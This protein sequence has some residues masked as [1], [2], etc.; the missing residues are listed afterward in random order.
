MIVSLTPFQDVKDNLMRL[1]PDVT[2]DLLLK[3]RSVKG[4]RDQQRIH[5]RLGTWHRKSTHGRFAE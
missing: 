4:T 2:P 3:A 1:L 5:A